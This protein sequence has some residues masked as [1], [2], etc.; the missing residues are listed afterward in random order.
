MRY[1]GQSRSEVDT[2]PVWERKLLVKK[3]SNIIGKENGAS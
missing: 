1:T 3:V 2:W